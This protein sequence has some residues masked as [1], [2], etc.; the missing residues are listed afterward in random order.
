MTRS[1]K[2]RKDM[3]DEERLHI[4]KLLKW[5]YLSKET[6]TYYL[7]VDE[8][9]PHR[10]CK[11]K[12]FITKVMFLTVVAR[13]RFDELGDVLF[14]GK[15]GIFPFTFEVPAKRKSK[16]RAAGNDFKIPRLSKKKM[17]KECRLPLSLTCN[18]ELLQKANG[19]L[20]S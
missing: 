5:F 9:E 13:P 18:Y 4:F 11:S 2:K 20:L 1:I 14:D 6:E 10:T 7:T 15:I 3:T 12:K 19:H 8:V 17:E 16:N